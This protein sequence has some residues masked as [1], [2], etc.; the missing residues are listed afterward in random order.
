MKRSIFSPILFLLLLASF[1]GCV[2]DKCNVQIKYMR[3][4][5]VYMSLENFR[6]SVQVK[7][8]SDLQNPGKIFVNNGYLFVNEVAKGI[9]IYDNRNPSSPVQ[10]AFINIPGNYDLALKGDRLYCDSSID[11]LI[12][13]IANPQQPILLSRVP[14]AFPH[15]ISYS[16]YNADPNQG[17]VVD[18]LEEVIT[19]KVENC[20]Q[21]IPMVWQMNQIQDNGSVQGAQ[22]VVNASNNALRTLN[23]A[24][25]GSNKGGSMGRFAV[26]DAY[27][28]VI[29]PQELKVYNLSS[30]SA[31]LS[32]TI[33]INIPGR[34]CQTIFPYKN[35]MFI[36]A[37]N[38]MSIYDASNAGNPI[39]V[40]DIAHVSSCDPVVANDN[41]AYVSLN[42][43]A[44]NPCQGYSN[45]VEV[46]DIA[47]PA[48]P[49]SISVYPMPQP[50][51]IGLDN[52]LFFVS[53]G[54]EGL[55]VYDATE[56]TQLSTHQLATFGEMRGYDVIPDN[57]NLIFVG[58]DGIAQY[59]Y[60]DV[61]HIQLLSKIPVVR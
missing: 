31:S 27:L 21:P 22:G 41:Y 8:P 37:N 10:V 18:W 11:L 35:L 23:A 4:T 26:K 42:N 32:N 1:S 54:Q 15:M 56:P 19:E 2:S 47:N 50:K 5:P 3:Y 30:T 52:N 53:D 57:G 20:K 13:D 49:R 46:Y 6:Q 45:Q 25:N 61:Q 55:K 9:H 7:A 40:S 51:G 38:G 29:L 48:Q 33:K 39:P 34:E 58:R 43:A 16:G 14:N 60:T 59:S 44:D 17:I 28:Y 12:F 24:P 36:G